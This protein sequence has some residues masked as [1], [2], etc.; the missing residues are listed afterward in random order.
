[1][2]QSQTPVADLFEQYHEALAEGDF[3]DAV[4]AAKQLEDV[5]ADVPDLLEDFATAARNGE[6]QV[7]TTLLVKIDKEYTERAAA[8]Q[9]R[10]Q[11]AVAA[12]GSAELSADERQALLELPQQLSKTNLTRSSFL[13]QA[14]RY[15]EQ[16][17]Q[18]DGADVAQRAEETK[19]VEEELS[20]SEETVDGTTNSV[21]IGS[22]PALLDVESPD[23][24]VAGESRRVTVTVGNVG[25]ERTESLE[26]SVSRTD[27]V[28]VGA[29]SV[30]VGEVA[31]D[32]TTDVTVSVR[33]ETVG[34]GRVEF[35]LLRSEETV[36]STAAELSVIEAAKSVR[37][38]ITGSDS[39]TL[40][41]PEI[42]QAILYWA[43]D[44]EVPGTDGK[45]ISTDQIQAFITEWLDDGGDA[46]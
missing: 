18:A 15:L 10:I 27:N 32:T 25:D 46:G 36:D 24:V 4:R 40:S 42:Q 39:A 37:A 11:R 41:A 26:L 3:P 34:T 16:D 43:N 29:R 19:T 9:A 8:E 17:E 2:M 33:S 13:T 45:T 44:E 30:S 20:T 38:A 1:M 14:V 5:S 22:T 35:E 7:A 21:T 28:S 31:T 6:R 23:S 12:A